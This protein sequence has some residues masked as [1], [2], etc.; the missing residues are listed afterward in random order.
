MVS[1]R[2]PRIVIIICLLFL[3]RF[4]LAQESDSLEYK[5]SLKVKA[6]IQTRFESTITEGVAFS[7]KVDSDAVRNNFRLRRAELRT[8]YSFNPDMKGVI[9][10]QLPA[11]K[12]GAPGKFLELAYLEWK[13]KD[14]FVITAGQFKVPFDLDELTSH[15]DLRMVDRG[16]TSSLLSANSQA[17]YQPG[18][19]ISGS[20][21][22]QRPLLNYFL[23][24]QNG[25]DR[26][27]NFDIDNK[28][29]VTTRLEYFILKE[30]RLGGNVQFIGLMDDKA[31]GFGG[32]ISL[33]KQLGLKNR[34]I[35][36]ASYSQGVN[37][38][39]YLNDSAAVKELNDYQL[40]GYLGQLLW[41]TDIDK[42]WCRTF[43]LGARYE[44]TNPL[45]QVEQDAF[46]VMTGIIGFNF[47]PA[48]AAR[49]QL[50]IENYVFEK[51]IPGAVKNFTRFVAQF[52]LYI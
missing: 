21:K 33:Q 34:L 25:S 41:K 9:R 18:I 28:K 8:D 19:M 13:L 20:Y 22:K 35:A 11:L 14:I 32:D 10:V 48:N 29:N 26:A 4:T 37:S 43:E 38:S 15:T 46:S 30:L 27:S 39:V 50:Q 45:L 47:L 16:T 12:G 5:P 3:S 17:L 31:L 40:E 24:V 7:N 44:F 36:E 49:L 6:L 23:A 51:Q 52:Q 42:R 1:G 2:L